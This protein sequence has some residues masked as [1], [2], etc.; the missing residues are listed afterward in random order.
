VLADIMEWDR[1]HQ[2]QCLSWMMWTGDDPI[3]NGNN[4]LIIERDDG[5]LIWA[6]YSVDISAGQD[7][8][9]NVPLTGS[10]PIAMGCQADP[11]CWADTIATC[12]KLIKRFDA[13][14]PEKLVDEAVKTLTDL[15]MLRDGDEERAMDL[16]A[17][18]VERQKQLPKEL[19]NFRYLPD[20]FGNCPNDLQLCGDGGCGTAEQCVERQCAL[21]QHWCD[22]KQLCIGPGEICTSC[23]NA[24]PV[25][26]FLSN[27]CVVT[28]EDCWATCDAIPGQAYCA[29]FNSCT[30]I[31]QCPDDEDGGGIIIDDPGP[32]IK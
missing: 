1:F 14:N 27:T 28:Q 30:E 29:V 32:I 23:P 26:C 15:D 20:E 4:N 5:K 22:S 9:M 8:Y 10:S 25:Y 19:E 12:E 31:G 6:P 16:R 13:L 2:F 17:W 3:H 11:A 21:G 18:F 7:W 24:K